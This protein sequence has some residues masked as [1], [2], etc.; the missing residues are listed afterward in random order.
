[1]LTQVLLNPDCLL[2]EW[3]PANL[4]NPFEAVAAFANAQSLGQALPVSAEAHVQPAEAESPEI[5][6][7]EA[8]PEEA[9]MLDETAE[10]TTDNGKDAGLPKWIRPVS[11]AKVLSCW[12]CICLLYLIQ[13]PLQLYCRPDLLPLGAPVSKGT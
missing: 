10:V 1:M 6:E 2:Q 11:H 9:A 5:S 7:V 12:M 3:D 8:G 13:D 4:P